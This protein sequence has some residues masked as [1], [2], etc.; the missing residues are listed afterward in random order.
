[1]YQIVYTQKIGPFDYAIGH[2]IGGVCIMNSLRFGDKYEKMVTISSP[3]V[4]VD[5]FRDFIFK[6]GLKRGEPLDKL[7]EVFKSKVGADV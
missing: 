4:N 7:L 5:M 6:I 2:S 3:H 1:M